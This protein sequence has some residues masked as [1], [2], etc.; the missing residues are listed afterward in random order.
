MKAPTR[1]REVNQRIINDLLNEKGDL[2]DL[3]KWTES[4]LALEGTGALIFDPVNQKI[5]CGLSQR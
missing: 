5:Y 2:L 1:Q 4:D 3:T